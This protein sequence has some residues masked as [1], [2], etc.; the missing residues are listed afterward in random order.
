MRS[1]FDAH[2]SRRWDIFSP[3]WFYSVY[4]DCRPFK[5]NICGMTY[6]YAL[7]CT[8]HISHLSSSLIWI[9]F[10]CSVPACSP[11]F[12]ID[13]Y[14]RHRSRGTHAPHGAYESRH[15]PSCNQFLIFILIF[16]L[17]PKNLL[18]IKHC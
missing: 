9:R 12:Q 17:C 1:Y 5:W 3:M 8:R 2:H 16:L 14:C 10:F 13:R 7:F 11:L 4:A 6:D 18:Q 15:Y